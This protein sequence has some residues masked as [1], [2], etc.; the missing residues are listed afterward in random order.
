MIEQVLHPTQDFTLSPS[1]GHFFRKRV[2]FLE[3]ADLQPAVAHLERR[4][5]P[6]GT[7]ADNNHVVIEHNLPLSAKNPIGTESRRRSGF[8]FS[9]LLYHEKERLSNR[10]FTGGVRRRND[11]QGQSN[12]MGPKPLSG[13]DPMRTPEP[14]RKSREIR[15]TNVISGG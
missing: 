2:S 8:A 5:D 15:S 12:R 6:A 11:G 7:R 13:S 14:V 4:P 3:D 1:I 9:V 10:L